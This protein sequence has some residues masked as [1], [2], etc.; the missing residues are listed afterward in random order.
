MALERLHS[1]SGEVRE[2]GLPPILVRYH[3][4]LAPNRLLSE[5]VRFL[6]ASDSHVGWNPEDRGPVAPAGQA[7]A[8]L[9]GRPG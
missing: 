4:G 2:A 7:R 9:D 1:G 8:D 6:V 3:F 5:P